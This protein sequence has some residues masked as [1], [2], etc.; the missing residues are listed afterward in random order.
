MK[1]YHG[2]GSEHRRLK[3]APCELGF[4]AGIWTTRNFAAASTYARR[5]P[6]GGVVAE[7][8]Y[9]GDVWKLDEDQHDL[10]PLASLQ[11]IARWVKRQG[12]QAMDDGQNVLI[13]K[14]R[15]LRITGYTAP[16]PGTRTL[17]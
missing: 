6:G 12:Y 1:L 8:E 4:P 3:A 16:E 11:Q 9:A 13:F 14:T 7:P 2:T 15:P 10:S 17:V 5:H